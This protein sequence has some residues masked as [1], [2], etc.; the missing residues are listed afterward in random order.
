VHH[1]LLEV[2]ILIDVFGGDTMAHET[3]SL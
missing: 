1:R 2:A 3:I